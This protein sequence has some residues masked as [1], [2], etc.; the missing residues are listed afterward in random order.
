[1]GGGRFSGKQIPAEVKWRLNFLVSGGGYSARQMV[2]GSTPAELLEWEDMDEDL[3]FAQ[4]TSVSGQFAQQW[5]L[6]MMEQEAALGEVADGKPRRLL[7]YNKSF[8]CTGVKIGGASLSRKTVNKKSAP[9]KRGPALIL[10]IGE[11]GATV[12]FRPQTFKAARFCV[13]EEVE[14]RDV[15]DAEL[16]PLRARVRTVGPAL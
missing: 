5:K 13:R 1:M 3:T 8:S 12:E 6:R 14:A 9:R 15:G 2:L 4:D 11:T 10:D 16:D 7:A